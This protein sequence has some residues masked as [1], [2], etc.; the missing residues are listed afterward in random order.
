[1]QIPDWSTALAAL[2]AF[3]TGTLWLG[4][5]QQR[6]NEHDTALKENADGI[7]VLT[8]KMD[9]HTKTSADQWAQVQRAL[10]RIEGHIGSKKDETESS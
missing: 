9:E 4:R 6:L 2:A 1:M 3:F 8:A 7:D 10:G 5:Q